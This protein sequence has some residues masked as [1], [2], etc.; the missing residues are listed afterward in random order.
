MKKILRCWFD[1]NSQVW[2]YNYATQKKRMITNEYFS[3]LLDEYVMEKNKYQG[4][5]YYIFYD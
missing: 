1:R 2:L 3:Y 5:T 4:V